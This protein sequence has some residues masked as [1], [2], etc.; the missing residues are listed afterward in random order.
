MHASTCVYMHNKNH[1]YCVLNMCE[2]Q[3]EKISPGV[4]CHIP[5][6]N[7]SV[8]SR[9]TSIFQVRLS[10]LPVVTQLIMDRVTTLK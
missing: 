9:T 3:E 6:K 8:D 5:K 2:A 7:Y 10:V 4:S 1:F